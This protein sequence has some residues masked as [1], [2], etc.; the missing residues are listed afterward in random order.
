MADRSVPWFF[1]LLDWDLSRVPEADEILLKQVIADVVGDVASDPPAAALVD[2]VAREVAERPR[3]RQ[4][5]GR[6]L[7]CSVAGSRG[8]VGIR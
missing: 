2:E 4:S 5:F 1:S 6:P 3:A 7:P 8:T